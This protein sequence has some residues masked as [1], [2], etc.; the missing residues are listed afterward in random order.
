MGA[1]TLKGVIW[2][3]LL[4]LVLLRAVL[5]CLEP[6]TPAAG[7]PALTLEGRSGSVPARLTGTLLA[8]PR[9][10]G[11]AGDGDGRC[12]ALLQLPV[13]RSEL[14]FSSCPRPPLPRR[15]PRASRGRSRARETEEPPARCVS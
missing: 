12:T 11:A 15:R 10:F 3:L 14:Q 1:R 6:F 8:D 2:A 13:G 7:D 5:V 4:A 9:A